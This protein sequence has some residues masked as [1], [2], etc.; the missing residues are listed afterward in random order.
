MNIM[1]VLHFLNYL[2]GTSVIAS[3]IYFYIAENKTAPLYISMAII[4][5][6]PLEDFLKF[7]VERSPSTSPDNKKIYINLIDKITSLAFLLLLGLAI[8]KDVN[9]L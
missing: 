5:A 7:F 6:G 8:L 1:K 4:V 9:N 3:S 2:L